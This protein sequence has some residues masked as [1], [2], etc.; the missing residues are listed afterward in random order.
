MADVRATLLIDPQVKTLAEAVEQAN[1]ILAKLQQG[2]LLM[3]GLRLDT[4][5]DAAPTAA[6]G[7]GES[8]LRCARIAGVVKYYIWDGTSWLVVG[9]QT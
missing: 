3:S 5:R 1:R 6:P 8:N 9:V 7:V 2:G 4:Q